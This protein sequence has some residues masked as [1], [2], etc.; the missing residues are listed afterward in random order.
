MR[1]QALHPDPGAAD[2]AVRARPDVIRRD[3]GITLGGVRVVGRGQLDGIDVGFGRAHAAG[4]LEARHR[5]HGVVV[6][7]P[8]PG[9]HR[10]A[11]DGERRVADDRGT[12]VGGAHD[13]LELDTR[14]SPEQLRQRS[15]VAGGGHPRQ[16]TGWASSLRR[17]AGR[18]WCRRR[19]GRGQDHERLLARLHQPVELACDARD[20]V[21]VLQPLRGVGELG[22][23][24]A[25]QVELLLRL[26]RRAAL[27]EEGLR[28]VHEHEQHTDQQHREERAPHDGASRRAGRAASAHGA[29]AAGPRA[30]SAP[31]AS[32][33]GGGFLVAGLARARLR[34]PGRRRRGASGT[35]GPG[36]ER[37][38]TEVR[39]RGPEVVLDA[40]ELVVLGDPVAARGRARLDLPAVG[41]DREVGDRDVLGLA[42]AVR[43]HRGVAGTTR[44]HHGVERLRQRADLVDL[45]EDRVGDA[46]LDALRSRAALVTKRS[47]PTSWTRSP[48]ALGDRD[49]AVPVVL[50]HAVFDRHDRVAV[51]ELDEAVGQLHRPVLRR[52]RRRARTGRR[53]R[54]PS[55]RDRARSRSPRPAV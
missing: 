53:G 41:G 46:A 31:R 44:E 47:S 17:A 36:S 38:A 54:T 15:D 19:G 20:L 24:G 2:A 34:G 5:D 27:I 12:A 6:G 10:G 45:D 25:E 32:V 40:Q 7:Q 21:V 48:S 8:E 52:L 55:T 23:L 3:R 33:R 13:H 51:A 16:F 26:G 37:G 1:V 11:V 29:A 22:V 4:G 30:S 39:G 28:G 18:R 50:G 42:A 9:R 49:P 43:H 14:L 35:G